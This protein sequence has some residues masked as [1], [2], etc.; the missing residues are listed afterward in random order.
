MIGK[1]THNYL[2]VISE[3]KDIL[4][5]TSNGVVGNSANMIQKSGPFGRSCNFSNH[6]AKAGNFNYNGLNTVV[7]KDRNMDQSKDWMLKN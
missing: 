3:Y 1:L 2:G 7:E 6:L 4:Y 5:Q